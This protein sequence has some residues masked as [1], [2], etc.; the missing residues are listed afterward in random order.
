ML[1]T[2][3]HRS[4]CT[5]E[6]DR[7]GRMRSVILSGRCSTHVS[8][9]KPV[10]RPHPTGSNGKVK[11]KLRKAR[12]CKTQR[13]TSSSSGKAATTDDN[14]TQTQD[15][16]AGSREIIGGMQRRRQQDAGDGLKGLLKPPPRHGPPHVSLMATAAQWSR[17]DCSVGSISQPTALSRELPGAALSIWSW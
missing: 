4:N 7:K 16:A 6:V 2:T 3:Q 1:W 15:T 13:Q 5:C 17:L 8:G 11:S 14:Q 12:L 10:S 9:Q